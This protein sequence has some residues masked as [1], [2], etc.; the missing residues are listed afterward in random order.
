[1]RQIASGPQTSA[2]WPKNG[3]GKRNLAQR[4]ALR[5]LFLER[6]RR[7]PGRPWTTPIFDIYT[8]PLKL[9]HRTLG[10]DG[11]VVQGNN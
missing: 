2:L 8:D 1:M 7:T 4:R 9:P 5:T 11:T 6:L 3:A 10:F